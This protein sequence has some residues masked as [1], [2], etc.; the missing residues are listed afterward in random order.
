MK[1]EE[2]KEGEGI[3]KKEGGGEGGDLSS[4]KTMNTCRG[5]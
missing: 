3:E 2:L 1:E 4:F 5:L